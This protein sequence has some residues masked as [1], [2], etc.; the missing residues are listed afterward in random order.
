M[1]QARCPQEGTDTLAIFVHILPG[2]NIVIEKEFRPNDSHTSTMLHDAERHN[3]HVEVK[4]RVLDLEV[5][6]SFG[7]CPSRYV[8]LS[9]EAT[10][11]LPSV[12]V[13][14]LKVSVKILK[15]KYG[16][17]LVNIQWAQSR[18]CP[19]NGNGGHRHQ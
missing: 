12:P 11:F 3:S 19:S 2:L 5:P 7:R 6:S 17:W 1:K 14:E 18:R 16:K 13:L 9:G 10:Y 4:S 15:R 8:R